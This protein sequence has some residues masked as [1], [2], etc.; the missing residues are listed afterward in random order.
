MIFRKLIF[1]YATVFLLGSVAQAASDQAFQILK[2]DIWVDQDAKK[3]D[4]SQFKSKWLLATIVYSDCTSICPMNVKAI[5][6]IEKQLLTSKIDPNLYQIV[7][8]SIKS[9]EETSKKMNDFLKQAGVDKK[10]WIYIKSDEQNTRNLTDV[11]DMSFGPTYGA[12]RHIMHS[13]KIALI[14]PAGLLTEVFMI[15]DLEQKDFEKMRK[16]FLEK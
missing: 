12:S 13:S 1:L 11:I 7:L 6:K 14:S 16:H 2:K 10:N 15:S 8:I 9:K 3:F 5:K 4:V